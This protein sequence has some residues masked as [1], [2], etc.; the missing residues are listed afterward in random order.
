MPTGFRETH[1][2][3]TKREGVLIKVVL[4]GPGEDT[5]VTLNVIK[6]T[7]GGVPDDDA[8]AE[9]RKTLAA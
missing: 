7:T 3:Y 1:T 9:F 5:G 8:M 4:V 6:T 2:E